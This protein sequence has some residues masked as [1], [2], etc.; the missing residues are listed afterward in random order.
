MCRAIKSQ[1]GS[2]PAKSRPGA[3]AARIGPMPRFA[4]E[5]GSDV[6]DEFGDQ[7]AVKGLRAALAADAAVLDA[8]E[9]GLGQC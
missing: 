3:S 8:A 1:A 9:R 7:V 6:R 2:L 5:I 4:E